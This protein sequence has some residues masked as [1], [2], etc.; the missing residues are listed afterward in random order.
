MQYQ[1]VKKIAIIELF[2]VDNSK[3]VRLYGCL[4]EKKTNL[5]LILQSD[6]TCLLS[7][8]GVAIT[9]NN[10]SIEFVTEKKEMK[11]TIKDGI[12]IGMYYLQ[13]I[14]IIDNKNV[15]SVMITNKIHNYEHNIDP[16]FINFNSVNQILYNRDATEKKLVVANVMFDRVDIIDV[17]NN[18]PLL[19]KKS[20]GK[21]FMDKQIIYGIKSCENSSF[22]H[23]DNIIIQFSKN[24]IE[25][26]KAVVLSVK[27][28][29][30]DD[31][32]MKKRRENQQK[33]VKKQSNS[34]S[35]YLNENDFVMPY[36]DPDKN[37]D[38]V[39]TYKF[40]GE[41]FCL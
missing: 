12:I 36:F 9:E 27:R 14:Y 17:E 22:I 34:C 6:P 3:D 15:T 35:R 25:Y 24:G 10:F 29:V 5:C 30:F 31:R 32:N 40:G 1:L 38:Q 41:Y 20:S 11:Q 39:H 2:N 21:L 23:Y 4:N 19:V 13:R 7:R 16:E 28:K 8:Y 33:K 37:S 26:Y 18:E